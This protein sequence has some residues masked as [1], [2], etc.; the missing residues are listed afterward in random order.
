MKRISNTAHVLNAL[1]APLSGGRRRPEAAWRKNVAQAE[2]SSGGTAAGSE[3]FVEG[4]H[5]LFECFNELKLTPLGW[6]GVLAET[7]GRMA[8]R[9]R[10]Q[11]L[12]AEHP[13]IADEPIEAPIFVTGL[14]RTA[15]TLTHHIIARSEGHR[16]PLLWELHWT[17]LEVDAATR[18]KRIKVETKQM[19]SLVK[20]SPM[21]DLI[22]PVRAEKPEECVYLLPH[23]IHQLALGTMPR[24]RAYLDEH[25]FTEDY[26]YLKQALQ[27]LQHGRERKRWVL[28]TPE[29]LFHL[30]LL[31]KVFPDAK[32][33]WTHRDPVTV[34]GSLCSLIETTNLLYVRKAD[35][36]LIGELWLDLMT[37]AI[38]QGRAARPHLP[39]GS[40]ID[41]HYASVASNPWEDVPKLYEKLGATWTAQDTAKLDKIMERPIRDRRHEYFL[42]R[43]GLAPDQ[44]EDAFGDYAQ[45][46]TSLN[47]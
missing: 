7:R 9:F 47:R 27:V 26:R 8:N 36:K 2:A 41:V 31:M 6:Q 18:A 23:G 38:E 4:L 39:P 12:I 11:K 17:D 16:G 32:V 45:F 1:L 22:H 37:S 25:D 46:V 20:L 30:D 28:K 43:Y 5:F 3:S 14:P 33:V 44:V 35:L 13:E 10:V 21:Y 29:H 19:N 34:M 24:Y 40:L 15:T 42:S